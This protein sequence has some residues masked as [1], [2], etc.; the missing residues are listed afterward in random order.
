MRQTEIYRSAAGYWAFTV[1]AL[2]HLRTLSIA[3]VRSVFERQFYFTGIESVSMV[4]LLGLL[5]GATIATQT[6]A[7]VGGDSELTVRVLVWTV[8]RE[9]GP[10]LA[11][12]LIIA[13]SSVATATELAL[14]EVRGETDALTAMRIPPLD[15]L[16]VPRAAAIT[17]SAIAL[18][19]YFEICAVGG[20]LALS[21]LFQNVS[22][23]TQFGRFF[24]VI[25]PGD[26]AL[27]AAKA[28]CF[29]LAIAAISCYHGLAAGKSVTAIPVAVMRAVIR[30]LLAVFLIDVL[31]TWLTYIGR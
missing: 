31:F 3:P 23:L 13:R 14:M 19:V 17:L 10:L 21:A 20:G 6:T 16:V 12:I 27:P 11:A 22:F 8:V 15:Y 30:S 28:L 29:G 4:A 9:L 24:E 7:L 5:A 26:I 18:T 2:S 25:G 1:Y